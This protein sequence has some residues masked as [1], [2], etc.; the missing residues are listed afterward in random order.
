MRRDAEH[1]VEDMLLAMR[2]CLYR[3]HSRA[4]SV[5]EQAQGGNGFLDEIGEMPIQLQAKLLRVLQEKEVVRLGGRD[6]IALDFRLVAATNR[7]LRAGIAERP[8]GRSLLSN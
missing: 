5:F 3:S 6:S 8:S 1:L 2:R 4:C 7:D